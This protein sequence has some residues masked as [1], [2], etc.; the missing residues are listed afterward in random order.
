[1]STELSMQDRLVRAF[2]ALR[3][4][5]ATVLTRIAQTA[6]L[7]RARRGEVLFDRGDPCAAL[8]FLLSGQVRVTRATG[9]GRSIMLYSVLPGEVCVVSNG[10]LLGALPFD[11]TGIAVTDVE[12]AAVPAEVVDDLVAREP[13]FRRFLFRMFGERIADL[14]GLVEAVAFQKLDQR[15]ARLLIERGPRVVATHQSLADDLGV[16]REMVSR[17]LR[18]F[19][20]RGLIEQQREALTVTDPVALE[21]HAA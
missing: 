1:M 21:K 10:V 18:S 5:P 12:I 2:P 17:V 9:E 19:A 20:D 7:R 15:L 14:M 13:D 16:A 4:L 8:P 3:A 11:A 6:E